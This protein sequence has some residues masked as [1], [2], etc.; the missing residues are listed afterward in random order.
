MSGLDALAIT[1]TTRTWHQGRLAYMAPSS[2]HACGEEREGHV[3]AWQWSAYDTFGRILALSDRRNHPCQSTVQSARVRLA[4]RSHRHCTPDRGL[5]VFG[6][7]KQV[8]HGGETI[9]VMTLSHRGCACKTR[10]T[11]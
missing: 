2:T 9:L 6:R 10:K 7:A 8:W 5:C 4:K 11:L 1:S 3:P